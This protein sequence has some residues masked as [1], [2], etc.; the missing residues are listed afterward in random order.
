MDLA[1]A[2][3]AERVHDDSIVDRPRKR[4]SSASRMAVFGVSV[5]RLRHGASS[6][7]EII[8]ASVRPGGPPRLA[9]GR[10]TSGGAKSA[11]RRPSRRGQ[12]PEPSD[13]LEEGEEVTTISAASGSEPSSSGIRAAFPWTGRPCSHSTFSAIEGSSRAISIARADRASRARP[14]RAEEIEERDGEER[15]PRDSARA[16]R[17]GAG[18]RRAP[19]EARLPRA[20]LNLVLDEAGA[21]ARRGVL[22]AVSLF[23]LLGAFRTVLENARSARAIEIAREE[24]S[25]AEKVEWL[26]APCPRESRSYSRSCSARSRAGPKWW[27]PSSP[28]SSSFRLGRVARPSGTR[29][30][31]LAPPEVAG[32]RRAGGDRRGERRRR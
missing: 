1:G 30:A 31:R 24:L 17:P 16:D 20:A 19:I 28:S 18:R 10:A 12:P 29:R 25:I 6:V 32:R 23:D 4:K 14:E 8:V 2:D 5:A 22:L 3:R 27:S 21:R 9:V 15:L 26:Q 7:S 13:E 11:R